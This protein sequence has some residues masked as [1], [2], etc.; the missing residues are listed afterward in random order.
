MRKRRLAKALIIGGIVAAGSGTTLAVA[1]ATGSDPF[2]VTASG[3]RAVAAEYPD[4]EAQPGQGGVLGEKN[5]SKSRGHRA[6]DRTRGHRRSA[7]HHGKAG[8]GGGGMPSDAQATRPL[9]LGDGGGELPYTGIAAIVLL[10]AGVLL[11]GSGTAMRRAT[12]DARYR[13]N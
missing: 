7:R 8:G 1:S 4:T 5:K 9:G 2:T 3:I 11:F 13:L 12:R 6:G 10:G